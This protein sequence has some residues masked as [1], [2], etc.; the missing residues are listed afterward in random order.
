MKRSTRLLLSMAG[1]YGGTTKGIALYP[2]GN[3]AP[4]KDGHR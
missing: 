3:P 4:P 2:S 1:R